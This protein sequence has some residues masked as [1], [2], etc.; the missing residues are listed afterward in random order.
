MNAEA[1]IQ[2]IIDSERRKILKV[3]SRRVLC[4]LISVVA[5]VAIMGYSFTVGSSSLS[6]VDAYKILFNEVFNWL[7]GFFHL[8]LVDVFGEFPDNYQF[9]VTELRAPRSSWAH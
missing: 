6:A 2:T 3:K 4:L 8:D 9:I 5:I 1:D 7:S